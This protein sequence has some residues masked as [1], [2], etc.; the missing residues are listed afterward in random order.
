MGGMPGIS[1]NAGFSEGL[2]VGLQLLGAPL[3]DE[4]LL[5]AAFAAEKAL[6]LATVPPNFA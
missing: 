3:R 1:I 6:G 4:A 5:Q 2:P